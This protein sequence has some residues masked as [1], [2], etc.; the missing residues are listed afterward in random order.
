MLA[1]HVAGQ[2]WGEI[3]KAN[4]EDKA[5]EKNTRTAQQIADKY[6]VSLEQV[7]GLFEGD[8]HNDWSCVRAFFREQAREAKEVGPPKD[9]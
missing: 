6:G 5:T 4:D 8:C 3:K 2:S 7:M 9:K 1:D